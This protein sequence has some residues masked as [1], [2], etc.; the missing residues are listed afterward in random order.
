[1]TVTV[2][3]YTKVILTIIAVL[4][5]LT[6]AGMWYEAPASI[7]S[8]Q[9]GIPDTGKQLDMVNL[10]LEKIYDS[11]QDLQTLL[12]SGKVKVQVAESSAAAAAPATPAAT[13]ATTAPAATAPATSAQDN[14][15]TTEIT[16]V[17]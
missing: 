3:R 10:N 7:P 4:L 13:P 9:A 6:V 8:A 11:I 1:M 5:T 14:V 16:P 2:D 15:S 17:Q 12:C